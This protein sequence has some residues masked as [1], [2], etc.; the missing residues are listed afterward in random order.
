MTTGTPSLVARTSN[1]MSGKPSSSALSKAA[2][3]FSGAYAEA[4][5]CAMIV[6]TLNSIILA[7]RE[8]IRTGKAVYPPI[9]QPQER[10]K[11]SRSF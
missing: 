6:G 11:D 7:P 10:V 2:K 3:V 9:Y 4:P 5:R 8:I 1:S